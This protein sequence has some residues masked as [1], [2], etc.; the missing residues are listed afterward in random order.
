MNRTSFVQEIPRDLQFF[1]MILAIWCRGRCIQTSGHSDLGILSNQGASSNFHRVYADTAS[2]AC[3]SQSGN[4]ATTFFIFAAVIWDADE[5]CSVKAAWA[6]ESSFTVDRTPTHNTHLCS[7]VCSQARTHHAPGSSH[8]HDL[9]FIF[10]R[11]KRICHLVL[12]MSHP[13]LFSHLPFT[14]STSSSSVTLP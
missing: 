3:P 11:L 6:P 8:K 1:L 9:H 7:A 4:L 5:P 2:A 13:V 12:H 14:T 10:V